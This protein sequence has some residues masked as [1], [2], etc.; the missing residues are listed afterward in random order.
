M[1]PGL[2]SGDTHRRRRMDGGD[3]NSVQ[4]AP[5]LSRLRADVGI[6]GATVHQA[7]RRAGSVVVVG[8]DR[9]G[10]TVALWTPRGF[11]H[12]ECVVASGSI[13]LRREQGVVGRLAT[14]RSVRQP[15]P[16]DDARR[17]RP[18]GSAD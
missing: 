4:P 1:G 16:S 14:G 9:G 7:A 11:A 6:A 12:P 17:T 2:G 18:Q 8:K 10:R 3:T 15:W 5:I 13:A